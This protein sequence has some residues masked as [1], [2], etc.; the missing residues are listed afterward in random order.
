MIEL[1]LYGTSGCHLCEQAEGVLQPVLAH[2]NEHLVNGGLAGVAVVLR[3]V[4]I[5]DDPEL[6]QR[7]SLSIPVIRLAESDDE[8]GWPFDEAQAW[9]FLIAQLE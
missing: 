4:E 3:V 1:R 2:I 6:M 8:L 7:Y 9:E 5:T